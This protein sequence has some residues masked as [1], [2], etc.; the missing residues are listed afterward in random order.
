MHNPLSEYVGGGGYA[1][2]HD[3]ASILIKL[4]DIVL[5]RGFPCFHD[6]SYSAS[7]WFTDESGSYL[8]SITHFCI[9]STSYEGR[10]VVIMNNAANNIIAESEL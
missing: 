8:S 1:C 9:S 4:I 2:M 7:T 5:L 6:I 10:V 3:C